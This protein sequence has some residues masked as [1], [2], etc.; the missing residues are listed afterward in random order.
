M[1]EMIAPYISRTEYECPHCHAL[2]PD[3]T[4]RSAY[5]ILFEDFRLIRE[6]WGKPIVITSGYRCLEHNKA[7]GG[8][9][10]SVHVFGLALDVAV[11]AGTQQEFRDFVR[12]FN[13]DIRIGWK[14]YLETGI[15]ICHL[16]VG[17]CM[18]PRP[19]LA[20]RDGVEW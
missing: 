5:A 19:S 9:G 14:R 18:Y 13:N 8:E 20:F 17:Y 7:I 12:F 10:C 6:K 16:D 15:P 3:F 1:T 2:P 4:D 11:K